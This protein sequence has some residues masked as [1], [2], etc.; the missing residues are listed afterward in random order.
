MQLPEGRIWTPKPLLAQEGRM[1]SVTIMLL[2]L[3]RRRRIMLPI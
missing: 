3:I 1:S 2:A